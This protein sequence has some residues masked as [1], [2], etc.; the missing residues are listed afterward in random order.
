MWSHKWNEFNKLFH[1]PCYL[2]EVCSAAITLD[3]I[4]SVDY[5]TLS[6]IQNNTQNNK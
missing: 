6:I 2:L 5:E 3:L 1:S 4:N